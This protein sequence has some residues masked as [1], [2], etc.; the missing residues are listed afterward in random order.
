MNGIF[1]HFLQRRRTIFDVLFAS[2]IEKALATRPR[3][4]KT[5]L[6]STLLSMK[7]FLL[8]NVKMPIIV[9]ILTFKGENSIL[10]LI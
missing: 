1:H 6:S 9:G 7:F 8:L 3:G 5:I 10:E 2:L 4:Y